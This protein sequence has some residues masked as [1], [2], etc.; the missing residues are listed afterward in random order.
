MATIDV[1]L[2][3]ATTK[4]VV[5]VNPQKCVKQQLAMYTVRI[6]VTCDVHFYAMSYLSSVAEPSSPEKPRE[7]YVCQ[8]HTLWS[9][10]SATGS[11]NF[12]H[13]AISMIQ[14]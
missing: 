6:L 9:R 8:L 4:D 5:P 2:L 10:P 13:D 12:T 11:Y 1:T 14:N 3:S 7:V